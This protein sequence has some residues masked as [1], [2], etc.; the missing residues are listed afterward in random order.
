M[1]QRI[2]NDNEKEKPLRLSL[3]NGSYI[4]VDYYSKDGNY[5][6]GT[7]DDIYH[8]SVFIPREYLCHG[9][10][11]KQQSRKPTRKRIDF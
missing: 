11:N 2:N 7:T 1:V 4:I 8:L 9:Q 10:K 6:C 5:V 3:R